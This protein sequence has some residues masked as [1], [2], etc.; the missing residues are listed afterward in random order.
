MMKNNN[1]NS[2]DN[3][4]D[5]TEIIRNLKSIDMV[6]IVDDARKVSHEDIQRMVEEA[7][8]KENSD[9]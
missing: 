4:P 6:F 7:K 8:K 9:H 2:S 5:I 1:S 3:R